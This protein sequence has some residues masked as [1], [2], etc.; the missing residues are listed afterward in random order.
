MTMK[1]SVMKYRTGLWQRR[2]VGAVVFALLAA[3]A[4]GGWGVPMT[5]ATR[6][7]ATEPFHE[8]EA[9]TSLVGSYR[10]TGTDSDGKSYAGA[11]IVDVSLA[12]SGALELA[13]DD[14]RIVGIGQVVG[15]VLAVA[16]LNKSRSAILTMTING[17][18]SLSGRW[19]R[20]TDR[21]SQGTETWVRQ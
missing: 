17:D 1:N 2:N 21:G 9:K 20:R 7:A 5:L 12:P 4:V 15:N 14:G 3:G 18:G 11:H 13:W 6:A 8:L 10:V 19:S 16:S